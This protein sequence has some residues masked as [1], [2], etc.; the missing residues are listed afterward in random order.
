MSQWCGMVC[1]SVK[2]NRYE[3]EQSPAKSQT[4]RARTQGEVNKIN[5][6]DNDKC[7]LV[8]CLL[9]HRMERTKKKKKKKKLYSVYVRNTVHDFKF[10]ISIYLLNVEPHWYEVFIGENIIKCMKLY[11]WA[12]CEHTQKNNTLIPCVNSFWIEDDEKKNVNSMQKM[13]R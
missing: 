4:K 8:D 13:K 5:G 3:H 12:F 1:G 2:L 11:L 7:M 10:T 9:F 6:C